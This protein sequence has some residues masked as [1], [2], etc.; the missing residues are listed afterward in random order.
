MIGRLVSLWETLVVVILAVFGVAVSTSAPTSSPAPVLLQPCHV[1]G[2]AEQ[3]LCGTYDVFEDRDKNEGRRI[4]LRITVLPAL[5]RTGEP[6]PLVVLAGGPGQG[7]RAYAPLVPRY[8]QR[9]R[10]TRDIVLVDV[11]GTG[12]SSPLQC[13]RD[14]STISLLAAIDDAAEAARKCLAHLGADP[15]FYTH[16][17][18]MADLRDV[19]QALGYRHVN[20]WGGSW[21]TRSALVFAATYPDL[22]RRA[23]LDG[24]VA[25]VVN[26]P[27]SYPTDAARALDRL[28]NDCTNDPACHTA[29]PQAR[30]EVSRWLVGLER[31]P[32]VATVRHPRVASP[33]TI[34]LERKGAAEVIRAAIYSPLDASRI[35]LAIRHAAQGDLGPIVAIAERTSNWSVDTMAI[36]Q[37]FTI[38]CSEDVGRHA[39]PASLADTLF[40]RSAIDFWVESCKAWPKGRPLT[41]TDQT[42]LD[43][44]A[45]ILSGEIDPVTPPARGEDMRK[46]FPNSLHVVA[47]GGGHNVSFSG[48][49]PRLIGDFIDA[50]DWRPLDTSCAASI[51]RPPFV[52]SLA[53]G[54]P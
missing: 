27:W 54:R 7:A 5:G 8:F 17:Y 40:G 42:V 38:L 15:R 39:A 9:V 30:D 19:L 29:F 20:L 43:V 34:R 47:P 1:D 51:T 3:V 36:G 22:V 32:V 18:S 31:Q 44:P 23:V 11:R 16:Y 41:I 35:L 49:I 53:G 21:G 24:A 28:F 2:V 46:H 37:T 14:E 45:L 6:D 12:D 10:R 13:P 50:V 4:T 26:F 52:T 33:L 48:C 25:S